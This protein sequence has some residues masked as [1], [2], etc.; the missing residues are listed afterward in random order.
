MSDATDCTVV[1]VATQSPGNV[2]MAARAM[3]NF[4][5][6]D[7][8]LIEP[9]PLDR[10]GEAYGFAGQARED[11]LPNATQTSLDE[12]IETH[13]TVGF[14]AVTNENATSHVRYPYV[15]PTALVDELH[16][17]DSKVA[18]VFGRERTGLTNDELARLDRI[19]SIPAA[20]SYPSLNLGQAV[21]IALYELQSLT[22]TD[23]QHPEGPI[24]RADELA[25]E[26]LY[27][28]FASLLDAIGHPPEKR[29][30]TMRMLRRLFGRAHPT[31]REVITL[32]GVLRR[33][34][35]YVEPP[36]DDLEG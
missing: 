30:K 10:D 9:P 28:H 2:G 4:G 1:L 11:V 29:A 13:Y 22:E 36:E 35:A 20:A 15:T 33:S 14:T 26:Q 24:D 8:R 21:T 19:C 12:L 7:L 6:G 32:T 34:A 17:L 25:I 5:F 16:Q 3:K 31:G 23:T 27:A 18:L